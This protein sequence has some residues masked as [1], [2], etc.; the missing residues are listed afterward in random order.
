MKFTSFFF[1]LSLLFTSLGAQTER[2]IEVT[3][4]AEIE[5]E[6]DEIV[7]VIGISEYWKEEFKK[8]AD[9]EDYRTKVGIQEVEK[10]LIEN[11]KALGISEEDLRIAHAGNF[12]RQRGKAFLIKKS[13]E[14]HFSDFDEVNKLFYNLNIRGIEFMRI[15]EL[16]NS[17]IQEYRKQAKIE[18]LK[19]A[20]EK[21]AYLLEGLG[22][23]LGE[24]ISIIEI[25]N[26]YWTPE[27]VISNRV[28]DSASLGGISNLSKIKL[29]Y[30]I[31]TKFEIK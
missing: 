15:D 11:L 12:Y 18:A 22:K 2:F 9:V 10:S 8:K 24:V 25:E 29:S 3:G 14:I 27:P 20:M 7:F 4:S 1:I 26:D 13:I 6:P 21:A 28:F 30:S 5:I 17:N 23:E 31:K 16:R 19:A